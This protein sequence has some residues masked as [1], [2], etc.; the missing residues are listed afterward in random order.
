MKPTIVLVHG[1]FAESSSW[2]DIIPPLQDAG[3]D[4]VAVANPLRGVPS[5]SRYVAD[6]VRS[7]SG[8]VVLVGH[9]YGGSVISDV[10][11]DAGQ[12][13]ALVYLSGFAPEVGESPADLSG[14]FPGSTLGPTLESVRQS[15]GPADLY[16]SQKHYHDQ[17][18]ADL[19]EVMTRQMGA[20]QRP[21]LE[22]AFADK[23]VAPL[24]KSVPSWF[25]FGELDRNIPVAVHRFMAERAGAKRTLEVAGASHVVGMSHAQDLVAMILEAAGTRTLE[26]A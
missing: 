18:A 7:L 1:A 12:I 26:S 17:F 3:H 15:D 10:P 9:S 23:A 11:A 5:D 16:I 2:N 13:V 19:P 24:W 14:K 6:V 20:T 4:V 25:M 8:P 22:S 21:I